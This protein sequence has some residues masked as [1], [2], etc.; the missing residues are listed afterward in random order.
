MNLSGLTPQQA[1]AREHLKYRMAALADEAGDTLARAV[2]GEEVSPT[3]LAACRFVVE[4]VVGKPQQNNEVDIH[5]NVEVDINSRYLA[6][7]KHL[8]QQARKEKEKASVKQTPR[9]ALKA[10]AVID[11]DQGQRDLQKIAY[12]E[13]KRSEPDH[14]NKQAGDLSGQ[15]RHLAQSQRRRAG[16]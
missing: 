13:R 8:A 16:R 14:P 10:S 4:H 12:N 6:A 1:R 3:E 2:R 7:L 11:V 15:Q 5:A 9:Q